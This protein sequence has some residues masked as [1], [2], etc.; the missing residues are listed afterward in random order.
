MKEEAEFIIQPSRRFSLN[1]PELWH[2][3][4][5]FYFFTWRDVKVKYKQTVLGI[6]W[7]VL[8]PLL[9]TVV[10]T[11][12]IGRV[13][14]FVTTEMDYQVFA[15]SGLLLWNLFSS[16]VNN[17]GTA[18]LTNAPIIKKIYF[19]RLI[20][21]FS[22]IL[23]ALVDLS[24]SLLVFVIFLAIKS[25][26]MN[27]LAAFL[28]WPLAIIVAIIGT[29]GL[30]SWLSALSVKYRDF[31]FVVPFLIQLGLFVTPVLYP[32]SIFQ[33]EWLR[34]VLAI[35]PMY[36]AVTLFRV[37]LM[38]GPPDADL[39]GISVLSALTLAV[40]GIAYFKKTESFFADLA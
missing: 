3:R 15:F 32:V 38:Q 11:F 18:M 10:F 16:S 6:L 30:G 12:T 13:I 22:S 26:Y 20:I 27:V 23:V 2:Y 4:E 34:Y 28:Y 19:P 33:S 29:A 35:N 24:V 5:L 25:V 7:V 31:R 21:P 37:P 39:I 40:I 36:G 14:N 9:M 1:I 8:Q 17:A